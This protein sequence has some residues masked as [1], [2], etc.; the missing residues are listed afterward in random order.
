MF[1]ENLNEGNGWMRKTEEQ[2][3]HCL[4]RLMMYIF[5]QSSNLSS[6][7]KRN[8]LD[9]GG[10]WAREA[11]AYC[12]DTNGSSRVRDWNVW[13]DLLCRTP[14]LFLTNAMLTSTLDL[15]MSLNY[16]EYSSGAQMTKDL[17][18]TIT[19]SGCGIFLRMS[20]LSTPLHKPSLSR[21][22]INVSNLAIFL[23]SF[24]SKTKPQLMG[25]VS[26]VMPQI[27]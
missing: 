20:S 11:S 13:W 5:G 18:R 23:L 14:F 2:G 1:Y 3:D 6:D 12:E 26:K 21:Q 25:N 16:W 7:E 8:L 9:T 22:S 15:R 4:E 19:L 17:M 10:F 27:R 24:S